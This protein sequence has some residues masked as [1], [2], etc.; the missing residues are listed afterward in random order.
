MNGCSYDYN[1]YNIQ[2]NLR[3]Q[4]LA[5]SECGELVILRILNEHMS[6]KKFNDYCLKL[7]GFQIFQL[8][9]MLDE[10]DGDW[11]NVTVKKK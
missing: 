4:T 7:G 9:K 11:V 10:R 2:G 1:T 6:D 3:D 5:D 8:V